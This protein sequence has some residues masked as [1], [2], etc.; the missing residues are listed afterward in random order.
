MAAMAMRSHRALDMS[1]GEPHRAGHARAAGAHRHA[2]GSG[3][4]L[5]AI[6]RLARRWLLLLL[7]GSI[8]FM[9]LGE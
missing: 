9:Y 3:F 4:V 8:P 5:R 2:S 1:G 6:A 7:L